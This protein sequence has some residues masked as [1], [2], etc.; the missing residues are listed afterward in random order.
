MGDGAPQV[1]PQWY[2]FNDEKTGWDD[3]DVIREQIARMADIFV[4]EMGRNG[5]K[6][7][8]LI[9]STAE[10]KLVARPRILEQDV[11]TCPAVCPSRM[12]I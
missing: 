7:Q 10:I 6:R 9:P 1:L 12:L 4:Q 8:N 5:T 2:G 3:L 11:W